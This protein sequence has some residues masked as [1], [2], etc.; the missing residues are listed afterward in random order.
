[1][2]N[3]VEGI[4]ENI[5]YCYV[6]NIDQRNRK[7]E[8]WIYKRSV[9]LDS[10]DEAK[11][12]PSTVLEKVYHKA[13]II[14][15]VEMELHIVHE[16]ETDIYYKNSPSPIGYCR[17]DLIV[18]N[19]VLVELKSTPELE[20]AHI[21]QTLNYMR[22]FKIPVGIVICFGGKSVQFKRLVLTR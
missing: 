14:E 6:L 16:I 4:Y 12:L 1:M 19:A 22:V 15:L 3:S 17:A 7:L 20:D 11:F 2:T 10:E 21:A 13:M 5:W 18:N 8:Q 9:D